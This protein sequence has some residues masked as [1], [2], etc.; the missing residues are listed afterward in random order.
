MS[1]F[2]PRTRVGTA[3]S[4]WTSANLL[5]GATGGNEVI[6]VGGFAYHVFTSSGTF[7]RNA[8]STVSIASVGGGGGGGSNYAGGG[9]AG[10]IDVFANFT[11]ASNLT[12]TIGALG[13]GAT[14]TND[15]GGSGGTTTVVE[16]ASTLQSALGGGGGG[17][18]SFG[19]GAGGSGGG[20]GGNGGPGGP[21]DAG[22][23]SGSNTFAG[24]VGKDGPPRG[25][26]GG[27]G[28]TAVGSAYSGTTG[29]NG[30]QGYLLTTLDANLTSANFPTSLT[31]MTRISS[32][33]GG[34][35]YDSSGNPTAGVGG[36][37]AGNGGRGVGATYTS[38]TDATAYGCGGGGQV[39]TT[40]Q[41]GNGSNG[42][43]G[44]VIIKYSV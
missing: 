5:Q 7:T 3:V 18:A 12:I 34:S 40:A 27:G 23:A 20:G 37:G 35:T 24:G 42:F 4:N 31:G 9:G 17:S 41:I 1:R 11:I 36:T 22:A 44:I 32:G 15:R 25:G 38:S 33:G 30:G 14:V 2:A 28:A 10:E 19:G 39:G 29:G 13:T 43:A 16:G 8:I 21:I 6:V 26:G